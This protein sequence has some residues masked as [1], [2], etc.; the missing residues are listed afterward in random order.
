MH[1]HGF[2]NFPDDWSQWR[3]GNIGMLISAGID[4]KSPRLNVAFTKCGPR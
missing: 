1:R 3:S 2:P 4:P